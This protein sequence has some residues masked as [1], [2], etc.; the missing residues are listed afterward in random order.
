MFSKAKTYKCASNDVRVKNQWY[1]LVLFN[2]L[3]LYLTN[4]VQHEDIYTTIK[5]VYIKV[6]NKYIDYMGGIHHSYIIKL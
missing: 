4:L 1:G 5:P 6:S 2:T 3:F